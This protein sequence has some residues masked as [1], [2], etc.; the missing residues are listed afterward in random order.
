LTVGIV[1][2]ITAAAHLL[3]ATRYGWHRD[4]LYYAEA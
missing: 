4:E 3:V 2:G 1:A